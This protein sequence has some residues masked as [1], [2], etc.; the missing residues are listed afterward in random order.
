MRYPD[1][2]LRLLLSGHHHMVT[3]ERWRE[4]QSTEPSFYAGMSL[5]V[6]DSL[7]VLY[8]NAVK[9]RYLSGLLREI[10]QVSVEVGPGPWGLGISGYLREIPVRVCVEPDPRID[11]DPTAP[12]ASFITEWRRP[13]RYV[14]GVGESIPL[15]SESADLVICCNVVDHA[16]DADKFLS[17]L[18]RILKPGGLFFFDVDTFSALGLLKWHLWTKHR[19]QDE[20]LVIAHTYRMFEP[21]VV[22]RLKAAGFEITR[23]EGHNLLSLMV[24][25]SRN[26]RFVLRKR[27]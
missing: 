14:V 12:F 9:A 10:P 24:G 5:G 11:L 8:H 16:R 25:H 23:R 21:D 26:S 19:H 13:V 4:A 3:L 1:R 17:E 20:L 18:N 7:D 6:T 15:A 2:K 22:R 27:G